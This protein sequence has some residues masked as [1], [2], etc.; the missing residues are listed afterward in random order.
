MDFRLAYQRF[1][2]KA[3]AKDRENGI[4]TKSQYAYA[5]S[6][7]YQIHHVFPK[8]LG[9]SNSAANYVLLDANSH[10]YAHVLLNLALMQEGNGEALKRLG[11]V[12]LPELAFLMKQ[13]AMKSCKVVVYVKGKKHD[14]IVMSI[15]Q[16]A[17]YFCFAA[18]MDFRSQDSLEFIEKQVLKTA[19]RGVSKYGFKIEFAFSKVNKTLVV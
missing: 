13:N 14:P 11:Y 3:K 1:C 19:M 18:R 12:D 9:G 5:K 2:Q 16:A 8:V 4:A 6:K 15:R 17:T 10:K 7:A